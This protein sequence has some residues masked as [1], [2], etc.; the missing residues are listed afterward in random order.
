M[1][2]IQRI[3]LSLPLRMGQ[4][5]CYL[6]RFGEEFALIDCGSKNRR[7]ELTQ[8]LAAAGAAEGKLK[9]ILLTHGD[10]DHTGNAAH[11]RRQFG[12]QI[13]MAEADL[14]MATEGEMFTNRKQPHFL[15]RK[16]VPLL[17]GF[18]KG[19]R[20]QPDFLVSDGESLAGYGLPLRVVS[21]P[22]HSKGSVGYLTDDGALFSGDLLENVKGV[23]LST[24]MDDLAEAD[25]SLERLRQLP[26]EKIY[27]GHGQPFAASSLP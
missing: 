17:F 20:F 7:R 6:L 10:F 25:I 22:G 16:L 27:P 14:L 24:I 18:G 8:T 1:S 5:N 19:E 23:G 12:V 2:E 21:L 13:G 9:A 15:V 4:V 26:V 11:L 3:T